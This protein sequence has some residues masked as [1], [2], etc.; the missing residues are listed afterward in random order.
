MTLLVGVRAVRRS[1]ERV[2]QLFPRALVRHLS[3]AFFIQGSLGHCD[4][5]AVVVF[6]DSMFRVTERWVEMLGHERGGVAARF[7]MWRSSVL[8]VGVAPAGL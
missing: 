2:G 7:R 4:C 8:A 1:S 3:Q 6:T 5:D